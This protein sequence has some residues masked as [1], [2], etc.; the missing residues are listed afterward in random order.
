MR[1]TTLPPPTYGFAWGKFQGSPDGLK[2]NRRDLSVLDQVIAL[3]RQRR[4]AVQAGGNLGIFAKRLAQVFEV[5]YCCEPDPQNFRMMLAN[6]P[7]PN[8]IAL[9]AALGERHELVG[10]SHVRRDGKPVNHEGI[11]HI[12]GPGIIPT[13]RLDDLGLTVCDLLYL[14]LEGYELYALRGA[15]DTIAACRPVLAVEINK[16]AAF[17]GIDTD[18]VRQFVVEQGY[19]PVARWHS[20]EVFVPCR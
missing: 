16:N 9:Q 19:R 17:F 6:A 20:D 12:A 8:I 15:V 18:L 3:T 11:R 1:A 13:L 5:V 2:W 4:V 7:E 14:D 10:M